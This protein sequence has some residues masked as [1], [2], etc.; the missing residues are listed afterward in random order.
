MNPPVREISTEIVE[1]E[2]P[3]EIAEVLADKIMAE[4]V[5]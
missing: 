3:Q 2:S 5:L 1:G 4:K